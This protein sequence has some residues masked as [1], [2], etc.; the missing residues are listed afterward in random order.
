MRIAV[1]IDGILSNEVE[2][3]GDE[4]YMARTPNEENILTVQLLYADG[5]EIAIFTARHEEDRPVTE[6]WLKENLIPYDELIM[7]KPHYDVLMDDMTLPYVE[8]NI[9][10]YK[11]Y[12]FQG[13]CWRFKYGKMD[14]NEKHPCF[15]CGSGISI[16]T[17]DCPKCGIMPCPDC[18][19]CL[20]NIPLLSYITLIRIH[21]KYCCNLPLFNGRIVLSGF[22]DNDIIKNCE[23]TIDYCA[24]KEGIL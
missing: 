18:G 15:F 21:K 22:V 10:E 3:W 12:N 16:K 17:K 24:R 1:D 8:G 7:D 5:H 6:K 14:I 4:I 20:C 11:S 13:S 23:K 9:E 2:G 19:K